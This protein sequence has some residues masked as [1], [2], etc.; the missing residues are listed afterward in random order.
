MLYPG[1]RGVRSLDRD[2]STDVLLQDIRRLGPRVVYGGLLWYAR[3]R[4]WKEGW[5]AH[6]FK[7]IFGTWP[8]PQDRG[9]P[10]CMI[11]TELEEWV[12]RRKKSA[13]AGQKRPPM[14][15]ADPRASP[16]RRSQITTERVHRG[17]APGTAKSKEGTS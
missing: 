11:G 7:E 15:F 4:G 10:I 6:A 13:P 8:R 12:V 14:S 16:T 2:N 5:A 3:F 9:E 17:P 1:E